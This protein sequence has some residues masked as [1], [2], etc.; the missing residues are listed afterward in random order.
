MSVTVLGSAGWRLLMECDVDANCGKIEAKLLGGMIS[1]QRD[2][3]SWTSANIAAKLGA[4]A[5]E[6]LSRF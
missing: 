5:E 2:S 3:F 6:W 1:L 4:E